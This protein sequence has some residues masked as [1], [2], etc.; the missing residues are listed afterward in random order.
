MATLVQ[1]WRWTYLEL[2]RPRHRMDELSFDTDE[3]RQHA[4]GD[5]K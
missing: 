5:N 2:A 1:Q 4:R 3:D